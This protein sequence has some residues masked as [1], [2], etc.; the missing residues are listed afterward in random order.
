MTREGHTLLVNLHKQAD[1]FPSGDPMTKP[2]IEIIAAGLRSNI[3][4]L[5]ILPLSGILS[6]RLQVP[7]Q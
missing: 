4:G 7:R 1:V 5:G 6:R 3:N 2:H